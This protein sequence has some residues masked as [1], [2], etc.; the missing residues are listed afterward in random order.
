[1]GLTHFSNGISSMGS[2]VLGGSAGMIP[3]TTGSYFFVHDGCGNN[4]NDGKDPDHPVASIDYAVSL[5]TPNNGDIIVVMPGH[6]ENIAGATDLVVDIAGVTIMG[7]GQGRTR[8]TLNFTNTAGSI[9]LDAANCRFSNI[10]LKADV[11]VVVVGINVDADNIEIDHLLFTYHETGDD[12]VMMMDIDDVDYVHVHDCVFSTEIATTGTDYAIR[13]DQAHDA[14]IEDCIFRGEFTKVIL[15]HGA[16]SSNLI[17]RNCVIYNSDVATYG[18]ID[19]GTL[20]TTGILQNIAVTSLYDS[21]A[22]DVEDILRTN[23]MTMHNVT[24]VNDV[25]EAAS[26][27]IAPISQST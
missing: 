27:A 14:I 13:L 17:I 5:C 25:S 6:E 18:A 22:G 23:D 12:F 7:I 4:S 19:F 2:P 26:I 24:N 11:G 20:S 10:I 9:E 15:G 21:G 16:L 3:Q 8:P 1:M